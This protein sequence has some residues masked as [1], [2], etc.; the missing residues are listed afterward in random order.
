MYSM[1]ERQHFSLEEANAQLPWLV[2]TFSRISPMAQELTARQEEQ[3]SLLERRGGNGTA[4][5]EQ[6]T[7]D[8][9]RE[10]DRIIELLR[11]EIE[12]ITGRGILI[13]DLARGLVD[14]PSFRD[15]REIYL[16]WILGEEEIGFW[17]ETN[18]GFSDRQAL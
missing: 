14:F 7:V 10:V 4:S 11:A 18:V 13:R 15:G 2:E 12:E 8:L 6:A 17:H 1:M 9:Q 5:D 3:R 16:C